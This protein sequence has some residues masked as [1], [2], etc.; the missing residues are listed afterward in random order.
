M[1]PA[2]KALSAVPRSKPA[3]IPVFFMTF[4][5]FFYNAASRRHASASGR[6]PALFTLCTRI[7]PDTF[8]A[9]EIP[10]GIQLDCGSLLSDKFCNCGSFGASGV[11]PAG[12]PFCC[13]M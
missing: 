8:R 1:A 9:G 11:C 7:P 10:P 3:R 6:Q 12:N 4:P 2:D 13:R 5:F